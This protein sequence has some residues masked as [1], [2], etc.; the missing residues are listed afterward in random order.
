MREI[1]RRLVNGVWR[2]V[3]VDEASNGNGGSQPGAI[4]I[5]KV[6]SFTHSD[7]TALAAGITIYTPTVGELLVGACFVITAN[8]TPDDFTSHAD[9]GQFTG[10]HDTGLFDETNSGSGGF[11][12][13]NSDVFGGLQID[14]NGLIET[15]QII[16]F[17]TADPLKLVA[18]QEGTIG[19]TPITSSAGSA[20]LFIYVCTADDQ[21]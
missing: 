16:T 14:G 8:W 10:G 3:D 12:L 17:N 5:V 20:D 1:A 7:A 4:R 13:R 15:N 6:A 2:T 19:G 11:L 21:S 18:S 9:I